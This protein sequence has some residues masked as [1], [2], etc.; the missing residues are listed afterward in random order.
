M[1]CGESQVTLFISYINILKL[2]LQKY[3]I[4]LALQ[5]VDQNSLY[6]VENTVIHSI[7]SNNFKNFD[8]RDNKEFPYD[9]Y[10]HKAFIDFS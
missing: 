3:F 2:F 6:K 5:R 8:Q 9:E 10:S 1:I 4:I 7:I